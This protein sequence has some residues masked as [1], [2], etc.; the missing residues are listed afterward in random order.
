[1]GTTSMNTDR[2]FVLATAS[3][4]L[5][6]CAGG[7]SA[8]RP[9]EDS[10]RTAVGERACDPK[11]A[12]GDS[13]P[14]V[15]D[16]SD[17]DRSSLESAMD[18]GVAVVKYSCEGVEILKGCS[19]AGEY[20]YRGVSKK[21]KVVKLKD[22]AAVSANFGPTMLPVSV[23]AE[24][25]Q[26]KSLDLAYAVVG[27]EST[28]VQ[29]VTRDMLKGRC[30]G[31]THFVFEASLGAFAL[32]TSA[33][34]EAKVAADVFKYGKAGAS[35]D[36]SRATDTS[37]GDLKAC[38]GASDAA[39]SKTEGCKALVRVSL[40]AIKDGKPT[41]KARPHKDARSCAKGYAYADGACLP[42][43]EVK[44]PACAP[45]DAEGCKV[46][47]RAGSAAS[48]GRFS[49]ALIARFDNGRYGLEK[50]KR[51]E[52]AA[53]LGGLEAPLRDACEKDEPAACTAAAYAH[54]VAKGSSDLLPENAQVPGFVEL[55]TKGCRGGD[56]IACNWAVLTYSDA[57]FAKEEQ[58]SVRIP[59]DAGKLTDIVG[60]GCDRGNALACLFL[61]S[62]LM[63]NNR[64]ALA[65]EERAKRTASYLLRACT[66]GIAEACALGGAVRS[67]TAECSAAFKA[68]RPA[69]KKG[70]TALD[71][72]ADMEDD[73]AH[74]AS[75]QNAESAKELFALGCKR[76]DAFSCSKK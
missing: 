14:F 25:K 50:A 44:A 69:L 17:K 26:G 36:T 20:A 49:A 70:G 16:W 11:H 18:R 24:L 65:P 32:G 61:S 30:D 2:R 28:T 3:L 19:V 47:C 56:T 12:A 9:Q 58:A 4:F 34:G 31:A 67:P 23:Q 45:G 13:E 1:M 75:A 74:V 10:A 42:A 27:N 22:Q 38:D 55:I 68:L 33:A 41:K 52:I 59:A 60:L 66:G 76:G 8:V 7:A 73:C 6:A 39:R 51:D 29:D 71:R 48:C 43:A 64:L 57:I 5:A 15:V 21:T 62:E 46:Q 53:A 63:G 72:F 35:G 40:F 54:L 37:D